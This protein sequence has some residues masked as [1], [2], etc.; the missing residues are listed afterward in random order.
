M[1]K[2]YIL[3]N[4]DVDI[5][6]FNVCFEK[7]MFR[8]FEKEITHLINVKILHQDMVPYEIKESSQNVKE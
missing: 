7:E 4:K 5:L 3:K 1:K 6:E 8:G 2:T